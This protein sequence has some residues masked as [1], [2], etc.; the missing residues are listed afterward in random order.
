LEKRAK[1]FRKLLEENKF[2]MR[3][4]VYDALSAVLIDQ[5]GFEVI[6]TTGYSIASV[7]ALASRGSAAER[8][9]HARSGASNPTSI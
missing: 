9:R 5:A 2:F 3:P 8:P 1:V 7:R 6:G 4:C